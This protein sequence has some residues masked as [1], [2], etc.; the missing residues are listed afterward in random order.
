MGVI[1]KQKVKGKGS[2]WWVFVNY[3]GKRKSKRIGDRSVAEE[4]ARKIREKIKLGEFRIQT[5]KMPKFKEYA[6]KWL[7]YIKTTKR[8]STYNRYKG[9]LNKHIYPVFS[10]RYLDQT[11][12]GQV[13][14]LLI[15]KINAGLSASSVRLIKDVISGVFSYAID[16]EVLDNNPCLAITKRLGFDKEA[17]K[18]EIEPL[19][20]EELSVYF[21]TCKNYY[22]EYYPFFLTLARTGMRLGE[23][24]ALYISD[25]DFQFKI[26]LGKKKL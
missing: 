12:R 21:D 23:G 18:P 3:D 17:K 26:Y 14:D 16:E 10:E 15:S 2:P 6:E 25:I 4:V 20:K 13:R 5:E 11:T 22:P 19:S 24:I 7:E 1:V 8:E 9:I